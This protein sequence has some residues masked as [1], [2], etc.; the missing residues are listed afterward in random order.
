MVVEKT[1][2]YIFGRN[3]ASFHPKIK[4]VGRRGF[5]MI[6]ADLVKNGL[7]TEEE[8]REAIMGNGVI[9]IEQFTASKVVGD[10]F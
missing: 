5:F 4:F 9:C 10:L 6:F 7:M 2:G 3:V 1:F 8:N